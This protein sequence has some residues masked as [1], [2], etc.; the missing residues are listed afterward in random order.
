[1]MRFVTALIALLVLVGGLA[2]VSAPAQAISIDGDVALIRVVHASPDTPAVDVYVQPVGDPTGAPVLSNVTFKTVSNYL[3]LPE[4]TYQVRVVLTGD[5]PDVVTPPIDVEV[6]LNGGIAY[7]AAATGFSAASPPL[8]LTALTDDLSA[9]APGTARVQVYHFSPDAPAVDVRVTGGGPVL[10]DDL[11]FPNNQNVDDVTEGVYD[12]DVTTSDGSIVAGTIPDIEILGNQIYSVFAFDELANI[13]FVL[14]AELAQARVVHASPNAPNVDIYLDGELIL[15][16]IPYFTVGD[17]LPLL[18]G[19]YQVQVVPTGDPLASAVLDVPVTLNGGIAYTIAAI[20]LVGGDPGQE[21][22]AALLE[23]DVSLLADGEARVNF[24]HFAPDVGEVS[25]AAQ[26]PMVSDLNNITFGDSGSQDI[27][28][29]AYDL[30]ADVE[31]VGSLTIAANKTLLPGITYEG[32]A[33]G[34]FD[35]TDEFDFA[36]PILS[37]APKIYLPLVANS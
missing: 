29:D 30:V 36:T 37:D 27:A 4:D 34:T 14:R 18:P 7:T 2:L 11:E 15:E 28:A 19:D 35:D 17:Y 6:P 5:D 26:T 13:D 22:Q 25:L 9:P 33:I 21:L 16:D 32:F 20:G 3:S 24:Y 23:D 12:L 31:S 8:T 10:I 1:M